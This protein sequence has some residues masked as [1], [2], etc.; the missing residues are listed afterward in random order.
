MDNINCSKFNEDVNPKDII[1]MLSLSLD[2]YLQ[3]KLRNGESITLEDIMDKYK[4]RIK[5]LMKASYYKG[6]WSSRHSN[7]T[8]NTMCKYAAYS[9]NISYRGVP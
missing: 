7:K 6:V 3:N 8:R 9:H 1:E 4:I 5:I 2:G